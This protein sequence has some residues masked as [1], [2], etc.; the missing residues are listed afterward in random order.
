[1]AA[2]HAG[3]A[4]DGEFDEGVRGGHARSRRLQCFLK[5]TEMS[6]RK[7]GRRITR[8]YRGGDER[9]ETMVA[10]M[11][12]S[13]EPERGFLHNAERR[14]ERASEILQGVGDRTSRNAMGKVRGGGVASAAL[15]ERVARA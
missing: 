14:S 7:L 8:W 3:D 13:H 9:G 11:L 1:M 6:Q 15:E 5:R 4:P 2:V 10:F 12:G